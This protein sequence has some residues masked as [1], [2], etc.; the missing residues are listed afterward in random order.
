[1]EISLVISYPLIVKAVNPLSNR[2]LFPTTFGTLP[3]QEAV[4]TRIWLG[5]KFELAGTNGGF[6]EHDACVMVYLGIPEG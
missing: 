4:A 2:F 6:T 3:F 5:L 1:M